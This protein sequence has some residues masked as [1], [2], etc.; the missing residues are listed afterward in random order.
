MSGAITT[1]A[2][3][4]KSFRDLIETPGYKAGLAQALTTGVDP[5]RVVKIILSA[6][7]KN[8]DLLK[9]TTLSM[10]NAC[11]ECATLNL[12]PGPQG[13]IYL[14]KRNNKVK[15]NGQE[16]YENQANAMIGYRGMI[17]LAY[18]SNV[19]V[20]G[21]FIGQTIHQNDHLEYEYGSNQRIVHRPKLGNR[22]D[23]IGA[24][25]GCIPKGGALVF[26]V[27]DKIEIE[28]I[29]SRSK[30]PDDGPWKTD[31]G[32]MCCKTA[33]RRL[34]KY[35]PSSVGDKFAEA[36]ERDA[37]REFD[38]KQVHGTVV[39]NRFTEDEAPPTDKSPGKEALDAATQEAD[40]REQE[41]GKKVTA[42]DCVAIARTLKD[43]AVGQIL[44]SFEAHSIGGVPADQLPALLNAL[45]AA[46]QNGGRA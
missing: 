35:L 22:G 14:I 25:V 1:P 6:M 45:N 37:E 10:Y 43:E 32:E 4:V 9:C 15:E 40:R 18:R 27:M 5:D 46:A 24:W 38:L 36:I 13:H 26:H 23:I 21:S 11:I 44:D 19:I 30:T 7:N 39:S 34:W 2:A 28:A 12:W 3:D 33:L 20:P 8:P 31:Y 17:E 16:R 29:R 41:T 42:G